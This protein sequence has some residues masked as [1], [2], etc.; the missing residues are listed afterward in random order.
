MALAKT[1]KTEHPHIVRSAAILGGRPRIKAT[2]IGVDFIGRF[3]QIGTGPE[4]IAQMYP[5][6]TLAAIH[7]AISYY[8]DHKVEIDDS[9]GQAEALWER[10]RAATDVSGRVDLTQ[11]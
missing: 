8:Y 6:L 7:D 2:R 1:T 4:E 10:L 9:I 3:L 11:L 5:F